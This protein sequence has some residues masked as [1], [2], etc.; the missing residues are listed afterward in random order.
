[1]LAPGAGAPPD[2]EELGWLHA[3]VSSN[4]MATGSDGRQARKT[5]AIANL[6]MKSYV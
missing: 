4:A 3:A 6:S 2:I 1:M 5:I